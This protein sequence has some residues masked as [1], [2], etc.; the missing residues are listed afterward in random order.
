MDDMENGTMGSYQDR[1]RTFPMMRSK[2]YTPLIFRILMGLNVRALF[3]LLL[4]SLG[5]VFYIGARTSPIIV[6][7]FSI[8]IISFLFA[9]Y[10]TKWVLAKDEGPP[11]MAQI[12]D[13]IRDGAEGFF[14][15]QYGTISKMA[16]LL[17]LIILCIYLFRSTT[18]QQKAA[19]IGRS[20]SACITV[21]A[22]LL[23]A[24]CSGIAGY[25]GM[26]VSVRANVRVSSAARRSAREALQIAVRA[27]GFSAIIVVG[28][29][30]I[31]VAILYATFFVWLGVDSPGSMKVT[32]L[33][34]LLVGY[35]FGAS[36]VA[37]FAQLGGGIY[38]KAADVG[39]DLVGKVEQGIPEDD[40]RNPA[41]IADLVGDNVGDCAA[42]GADLFESIAAEIISAM[43]LGGT[44]A[45]R[46]K[47]EDPSGFILFPLVIHSFDLVVSSIGILSIRGTR[48][49]GAKVPIEDPMTIIQKGYSITIFLAVLAFGASTRWLLYTDQ[50]PSAW[51]NFALCGLVGITT[52]YVFVWISKY[53]TD[54]KHEPVR[55]LALASTTGHGTNI[56]AGISLGLEST[57]LPV[58]VISVAIVSSFWLGQTSGLV[59]VTGSPT[60]GLF[61]TAVATMGMLSSAAYVLTMDMF[62][63][64]AD[65][66][67]GIVEMSQQPESVREIT[68][69][70][71]AVGNTTKATTKGFAIGS[72]ALASFLLFSAY[73]DEVASFAQTPFKEVDIAIPEVFVGGL[74]GSMLIFLFSAWACSAVGRTAQ[75]VVNEV[76]RQFIE[77]PGIMDYKEKPDY[78]RCVSIVASASLREM[79]K[80]GALAIISPIAIGFVFRILGHLTGHPLLGAK[81]VASMLMFATVSG[82]LMALFLNTAGGAWDNAKKF[83]E[84]GALGGKG[85]ECHKAAVTGDTVGDPFK[86]TAGPSLHVLIKMLA[87]ITLV[88]APVFL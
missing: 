58:L 6:F 9:I 66:A 48:E 21:V 5:A 11:E 18:P 85:S 24:L 76:R 64:I 68:D 47:I 15:T 1:P 20:T 41:V 80:P 72:A 31:G 46:C 2:P 23:G 13:A 51:L 88:M 61:G 45:Q 44:M 4:L 86:D 70:L 28:M 42:R 16:V 17:A 8:C 54:Y 78:S 83:I 50:A 62:G 29:A 37:L 40:P 12:S 59:D 33:P 3:G 77:R 60:G 65:N 25:V 39:A 35:G 84:T 52:A 36:F 38:T 49:S 79:I 22:F 43:I 57:A 71:D 55:T 19:G 32:D 63:P 27:G 87:T 82:I 7:V 30:V 67:G 75:E 53:Y 34:L 10:L 81:V 73:M 26:W 14:R 69:V 56:I 74:L